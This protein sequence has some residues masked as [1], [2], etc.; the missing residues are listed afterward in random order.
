MLWDF[1]HRENAKKSGSVH[2]TY[3]LVGQ[4]RSSTVPSAKSSQR[5]TVDDMAMDSSPPLPGSSMAISESEPEVQTSV[6]QKAI[7]LVRQ[8]DLEEAKSSFTNLTSMHIYSLVADGLDDFQLLANCNRKIL[9]TLRTDDL[10]QTG[11]QYGLIQNPAVK[12][13]TRKTPLPPA[14][15]AKVEVLPPKAANQPSEA[16]K[17]PAAAKPASKASL[18][19]K[20]ALLKQSS[21]GIAASFAKG[22]GKPKSMPK[23]SPAPAVEP[24]DTAMGGM[25]D[26]DDDDA[27]DDDPVVELDVKAP[28]G[29][30][31]KDRQAELE[32]MMDVDDEVV[33]EPAEEPSAPVDEPEPPKPEPAESIVVENGRRRGRRKVMKK[34]VVRDEEGY[35]SK[36]ALYTLTNTI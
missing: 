4:R 17:P 19:A 18:P 5:Y 20:P 26:D 9:S 25:S 33:D 29:K 22:A 14:T 28:G 21:S 10:L 34:K 16:N 24:S 13:R 8:E 1:H 15:V 2:A 31:K 3:L 27:G 32:A 23:P 30:T 36:H 11:K 35:L 7:I 6:I 12:R